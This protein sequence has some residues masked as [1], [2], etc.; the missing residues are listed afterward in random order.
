VAVIRKELQY[1]DI[2]EFSA[3][4]PPDRRR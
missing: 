2:Q 3:S 4:R 1:P